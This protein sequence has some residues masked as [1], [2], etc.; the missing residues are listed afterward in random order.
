MNNII[1]ELCAEDRARLDR[2]ATA[3]E[4]AN[5]KKAYIVDETIAEPEEYAAVEQITFDDTL[6]TSTETPQKAEPVDEAETTSTETETPE[7]PQEKAE[8]PTEE[9]PDEV[10]T[11][12]VMKLVKAGKRDAV[13]TIV[14]SYAERASLI[15]AEKRAEALERLNALEG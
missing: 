3:L 11:N 2:L 1:I 6:G 5:A 10:I 14:K 9:I 8:E 12:K 7:M 13:H 4:A 15:P